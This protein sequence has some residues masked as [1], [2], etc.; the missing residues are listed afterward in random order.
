MVEFQDKLHNLSELIAF[1]CIVLCSGSLQH[2]SKHPDLVFPYKNRFCFENHKTQFC[3]EYG[4]LLTET[5]SN[6]VKLQSI[7][8]EFLASL[9]QIDRDPTVRMHM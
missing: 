1:F 9:S 3:L 7:Y 8:C 2:P 6:T 5:Y 4:F